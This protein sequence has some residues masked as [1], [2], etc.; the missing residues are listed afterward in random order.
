MITLEQ[1]CKIKTGKLHFLSTQ[2]FYL[3]NVH[4]VEKKKQFLEEVKNNKLRKDKILD[5]L[6]C[7]KKLGISSEKIEE[8]CQLIPL[9]NSKPNKVLFKPK[10]FLS[11]LLIAG[12][13]TDKYIKHGQKFYIHK[14]E[15]PKLKAGNPNLIFTIYPLDKTNITKESVLPFTSKMLNHFVNDVYN[16]YT[17]ERISIIDKKLIRVEEFE[18]SKCKISDVSIEEKMKIFGTFATKKTLK[19]MKIA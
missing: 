13:S 19:R 2:E 18:K 5:F 7:I 8:I 11:V 17:S 12:R 1:Y 4:Y 10:S 15:N 16:F 6:A 14:L 3:F 9:N